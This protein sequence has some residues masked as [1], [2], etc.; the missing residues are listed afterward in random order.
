VKSLV[1]KRQQRVIS[2]QS[3]FLS[4]L[5]LGARQFPGVLSATVTYS[6]YVRAAQSGPKP[7]RSQLQTFIVQVVVLYPGVFA[8]FL[9][10]SMTFSNLFNRVSC[11][12][13]SVIQRQYSLRWV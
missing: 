6:C 9:S 5:L 13:T 1:D 8:P 12:F 10:I 3:A 7:K 4:D 2:R 11:F